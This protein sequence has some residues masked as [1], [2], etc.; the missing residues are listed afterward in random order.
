MD[1]FTAK[2]FEIEGTQYAI[3]PL[4]A[5][6]GFALME[7]IRRELGDAIDI[8]GMRNTIET[9]AGEEATAIANGAV[10][11]AR[12][13]FRLN[14]VFVERVRARL[15]S[16]IKFKNEHAATYQPLQGHEELAFES[17]FVI[18]E[19]IARSLAV[20]FMTR[21]PKNV[22]NIVG[23]IRGLIQSSPEGPI[24]TSQPWSMP[25][26]QPGGTAGTT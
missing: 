22:S 15:F 16:R 13:L 25:D 8:S 23:G 17:P 9:D 14:P 4:G 20:N 10:A 11:A 26:S 12:T 19:L 3:E 6:D 24:P 5:M 1:E 21:V 18:Y 2:E 7:E